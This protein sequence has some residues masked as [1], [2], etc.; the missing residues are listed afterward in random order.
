MPSGA[1]S[2]VARLRSW[3]DFSSRPLPSTSRKAAAAASAPAS[4]FA[5]SMN[6]D[7]FAALEIEFDVHVRLDRGQL[8][9]LAYEINV[10]AQTLA[11]S[12]VLDLGPIFERVLNRAE[13]FDDLHRAFCADAGRPRN[14]VN[15]VAHQAQ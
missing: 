14:V 11:V 4:K 12:F 5:R 6:A 2:A 7:V 9:R 15:R 3:T 8:A 13:L 10:V 1:R